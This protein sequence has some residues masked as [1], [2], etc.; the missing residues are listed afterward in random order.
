M[1]STLSSA[2]LF[3]RLGLADAPAHPRVGR[4]AGVLLHVHARDADPAFGAVE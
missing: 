3:A 1:P 4:L 2:A